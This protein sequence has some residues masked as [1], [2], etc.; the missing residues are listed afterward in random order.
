MSASGKELEK[1]IR[2]INSGDEESLDFLSYD[3]I[4]KRVDVKAFPSEFDKIK[5]GYPKSSFVNDDTRKFDY[6]LLA[7]RLSWLLDGVFAPNFIFVDGGR[8]EA[9][10]LY[11]KDNYYHH[12]GRVVLHYFLEH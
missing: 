7:R 6:S 5:V 12:G 9:E 3:D 4:K 8:K 10:V 1:F 2:K 11:K